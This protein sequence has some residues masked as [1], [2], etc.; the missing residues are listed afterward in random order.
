MPLYDY[1]CAD[2][3]AWDRRVGGLDDQTALCSRCA[4]IMLRLTED[5]FIG[6]FAP[7]SRKTESVQ[8]R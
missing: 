5:V 7:E 4:G 3:G 1:R 6:Y 8:V 2:C